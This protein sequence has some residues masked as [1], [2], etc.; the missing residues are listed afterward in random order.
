MRKHLQQISQRTRPG[1]FALVIMDGAGW[2][3]EDTSS[4]FENLAI[5]KIPPYSPEL[6]P[7][8]Q[9]WQWIRQHS[10]ANRCFKN[11]EE[12]VDA[13]TNAWNHFIDDAKRVT[14]LCRRQW[15]NLT[16]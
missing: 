3:T 15:T 8:E 7:I 4:E 1:R 5:M 9:V 14:K 11:Y 6:N 12:I 2:H 16:I 13:C 10:L